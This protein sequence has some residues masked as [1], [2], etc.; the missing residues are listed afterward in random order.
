MTYD[1]ASAAGGRRFRWSDRFL[2]AG[3]QDPILTAALAV[4]AGLVCLAVFGP[5][6]WGHDPNQVDITASLRPPSLAHPMGTDGVG[7]DIFAR[8][9]YGARISLAV[10]SVVVALGTLI[11]GGIGMLI[12]VSGRWVDNVA[13][14]VVDVILAFPPL[15]LALAITVAL[16]VG[17]TTATIG[18]TLTCIP[19]YA[20]L[21][22]SD[23]IRVKELPHVEASIAI[24]ARPARVIWRHVF[25]HATSTMLIQSAAVF[26]YA[27]LTLAALGFVGV[28]AQIP[29][30]EWGSMITDGLQYVVT[31]QW[32][33]VL[34]PGVG[35][36]IAVLSVNTVADRLRE[37]W[38]PHAFEKGP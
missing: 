26:G 7:R 9:L 34:F 12:G 24:G 16:G 19:Y 13:M 29:T 6:V 32:W 31:G 35:L 20:R 8:F 38:D 1:F 28:G 10:G 27:V 17:L 15:I 21:L 22:R 2:S 33:V 25:P 11:G 4:F 23:V 18:I 30:P 3:R 37:L 5:L 14:R 36:L